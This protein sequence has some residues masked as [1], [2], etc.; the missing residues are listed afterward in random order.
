M[1]HDEIKNSIDLTARQKEMLLAIA[2]YNEGW[3]TKKELEDKLSF[4]NVNSMETKIIPTAEEL[5]ANNIDGL[6]D[7]IDDE[8]LFVFYKGVICEF[9]KELTK[10]HVEQALKEASEKCKLTTGTYYPLLSVRADQKIDKYSILNSYPLDK[11]K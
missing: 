6:R 7:I 8:D 4:K 11:I 3:I 2:D 9:A 1:N 10:L 5:L